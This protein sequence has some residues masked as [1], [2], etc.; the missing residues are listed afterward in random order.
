MLFFTPLALL[1]PDIARDHIL[2]DFFA[3]TP[4]NYTK[5]PTQKRRIK[6]GRLEY[7]ENSALV[8]CLL[9]PYTW[10]YVHIDKRFQISNFNFFPNK[11]KDILENPDFNSTN[12]END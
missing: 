1:S 5:A 2:W 3:S 11:S 8:S 12:H 9:V 6:L 4:T 7:A 10:F